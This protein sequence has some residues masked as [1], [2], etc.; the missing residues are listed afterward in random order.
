MMVMT[1]TQIAW[2][3]IVLIIGIVIISYKLDRVEDNT[4]RRG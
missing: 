3:T 2:Q 4:R 1:S